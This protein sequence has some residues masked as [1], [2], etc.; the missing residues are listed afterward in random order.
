MWLYKVVSL[1]KLTQKN[2]S[3]LVFKNKWNTRNASE[4]YKIIAPWNINNAS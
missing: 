3:K 4:N 2:M 1:G